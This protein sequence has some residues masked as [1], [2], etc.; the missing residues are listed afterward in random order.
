MASLAPEVLF[1]VA[2]FPVTN[3]VLNTLFVD[4]VIIGSI[5]ALKNKIKEIPGVFQNII[6]MLL[7]TF[8]SFVES[9]A[10]KNTQKIFPYVVSF[11]IFILISNWSGLLPGVGTIGFWET[12][13]H[14]EKHLVPLIRNATSDLNVTFALALISLVATHMLGI[15]TVGIKDYLSRYFSWNPI[16]MY[17][18]LLEIVSEITKVISLSFRLFGN[19]YAGE[20][21]LIT[22]SSLFA[23]GFPVPFLLLE[24]IVGLV[25]ALVFSLLTMVFMSMIMTSHNVEAHES[26]EVSH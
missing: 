20:F 10:G 12:G 14:H 15:K 23:F 4:S 11:F 21:V 1:S 24:I 7:E 17:V 3:T 25:Q 6:E 5:L 9:V 22:I 2:S 19:I 16:N 18:G 26:K 13:E 8:Y